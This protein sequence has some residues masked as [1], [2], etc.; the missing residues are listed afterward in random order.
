MNAVGTSDAKIRSLSK[1]RRW[2]PTDVI[3]RI[4]PALKCSVTGSPST[5]ASIA[6]CSH[7]TVNSPQ[8]K[9]DCSLPGMLLTQEHGWNGISISSSRGYVCV[10]S[11]SGS[12]AILGVGCSV[13]VG[14]FAA[15]LTISEFHT[16]LGFI[17]IQY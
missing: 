13:V 12:S 5:S 17:Y 8:C 7:R 11:D 1:I 16:S 10:S 4:R 14:C 6:R 15:S 9:K 3:R 2:F